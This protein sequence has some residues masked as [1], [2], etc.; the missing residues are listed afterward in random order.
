VT[1]NT[2]S[3]AADIQGASVLLTESAVGSSA[4]F[5]LAT[6]SG[7]NLP[8]G[9][10][11]QLGA[12]ADNGGPTKTH[13]L[14]AGSPALNV[15]SNPGG[16][17]IDQ[18]GYG[19]SRTVGAGTD[20]GAIESVPSGLPS[21]T[22]GPLPDVTTRGASA[23]DFTV[24]FRDD[25][26]VNIGSLG[27]GDVRV[28]GP[29]GFTAAPELLGVDLN[30]SGTPRQATYRLTPPGGMWDATDAG[31]YTVDLSANGVADTAGNMVPAVRLG[32]F[33]AA[34][35]TGVTG[36]VINDGSRQRSRVMSVTVY[37]DGPLEFLSSMAD[38]FRVRRPDGT[39]VAFTAA[40][41][42]VSAGTAIKLTFSGSGLESGSLADGT[43]TLTVLGS[44]ARSGINGPLLD[45]DG[46]GQP[47]GDNTFQFHRLYGDI[48]AD[49]AVNGLD[50]AA[51]RV[52]FGRTSTD[53]NY[54]SDMDF[55]GDGAINGLDLAASRTRFGTFL[56]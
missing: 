36:T 42:T 5:S 3:G 29:N 55:N 30:T 51:F 47:G 43:Y 17:L 49:K 2:G 31:V 35:P 14:L 1:G 23:Y 39:D 4:G 21:A 32:Q 22:A 13:A 40:P 28:T 19:F 52:T 27:T 38:T 9:T 11:V 6:G 45:A 46:E 15:G 10:N 12:L 20:I 54:L 41:V 50:L 33:A 48:N 7:N 53:P 24:T 8:F 44:T 56:P 26:A 34:P 25:V 16:L 18:R 37:F